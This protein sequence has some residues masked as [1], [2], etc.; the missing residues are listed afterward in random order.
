MTDG[1]QLLMHDSLAYDD[2]FI[3]VYDN[4]KI[5]KKKGFSVVVSYGYLKL[6]YWLHKL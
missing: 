1:L 4:E 6:V 5:C 3:I 2:G